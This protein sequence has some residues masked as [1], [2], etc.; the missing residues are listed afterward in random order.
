MYL[1]HIR[2][3]KKPSKVL[4]NND[5]YK[6]FISFAY[7]QIIYLQTKQ[8]RMQEEQKVVLVIDD[9]LTV[10]KLIEHHL[11]KNGF[12]ALTANGSEGGFKHLQ[13]S[14][15]DLVLCDVTMQGMD[16]FT[17]CKQ[18]RTDDKFKTLPFVFV[19]AKS[20]I[21]D[22]SVALEVGADDII[23]KPFDMQELRL[24]QFDLGRLR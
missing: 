5:S 3:R 8:T 17:F 22:K 10:S 11:K 7:S 19:T 15:V 20:T 24:R 9:D 14:N 18:V 1:N 4:A 16:G 6:R 13:E 23:T 12:I 2:L 21:E